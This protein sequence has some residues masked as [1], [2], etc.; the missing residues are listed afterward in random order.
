MEKDPGET[1]NLATDAQHAATV[2][3]LRAR[4]AAY[5]R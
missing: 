5:R 4:L 3:E 2:N 1:M